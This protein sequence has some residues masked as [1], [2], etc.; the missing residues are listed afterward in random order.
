MQPNFTYQDQSTITPEPNP[1]Q[2][3][4]SNSVPDADENPSNSLN[5]LSSAPEMDKSTRK[6]T[7]QVAVVLTSKEKIK[8]K[9]ENAYKNTKL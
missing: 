4:M 2:Q 9:K 6:R 1:S 3:G 8:A 7:K 5:E